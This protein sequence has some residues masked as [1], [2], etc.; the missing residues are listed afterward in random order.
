MG[1]EG[2]M[3]GWARR[4]GG[5]QHRARHPLSGS[6]MSGKPVSGAVMV[7]DR[8]RSYFSGTARSKYSRV[9]NLPAA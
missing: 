5:D 3:R 7:Q 4:C 6:E 8:E 1:E 2:A 9:P